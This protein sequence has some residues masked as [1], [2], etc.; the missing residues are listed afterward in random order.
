MAINDTYEAARAQ[1]AE[2]G[3]DTE[4]ALRKLAKIPV[5]LHCWQG[6]DVRGFENG[7]QDLSGGIQATGNYPGRARTPE[8]LRDDLD[9]VFSLVP[10]CHRLNLH[11]SYA[12]FSDAAAD[13]DQLQ[14]EH[15]QFWMDYAV[16]HGYGLDFN[17]TFFSH[18]MVK[19]NL[20]LSS[21]DE[22]V[23]SFWV[24]HGL[25][26]RRIAA[27]MAEATGLDALCNIWI[28]D[29]FKDYPTDRLSP[30]LQL[31]RSLDEIL[32][33]P[34]AHVIDSL[35]SKTFGIG[36]EAFT[37]GSSDFYLSYCGKHEN[38][39]PLLDNGHFHPEETVSEKLSALLAFYDY[40]PLHVTRPMH[41]DSDHVVLLQDEIVEIAKE[42]VRND[43][44]TRVRIGLDYFDASINRVA[45]WVVGARAIRQALLIALLEP[46]AKELQRDGNF[47]KMLIHSEQMKSAPWGAVW[48]EFCRRSNV[49]QDEAWYAVVEQYEK[50]VLSKR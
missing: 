7:G 3:I 4:E 14:P 32:A 34:L 30:R 19:D 13:R 27:A 39:Y 38:V 31:K 44:L 16:K 8:E 1:Y 37:V 21:P 22:D 33:E 43:A 10:G 45:A 2:L 15:F 5:S 26:C 40:V 50:D 36:L 48:N 20:T 23:R 9:L 11:A 46:D 28:P 24:R 6:D 12:V 17:P 29:G 47:T 35:E 42:I 49:P 25:A 18:P 41:W